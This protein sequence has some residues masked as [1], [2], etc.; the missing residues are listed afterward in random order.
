MI[1]VVAL[2]Q[3]PRPVLSPEVHA[4][5]KVTFRL[6]APGAGEVM[7]SR[8]GGPKDAMT[9]GDDGVWSVTIG[10]LA[11]D[12]YSYS[13]AVDGVNQLDPNNALMVPNLLNST[14]SM[15][16]VP[17]GM[18]WEVADVPHGTVHRHYYKSGV[19]GDQRDYYV[20]TPPGYD[21]RAK[22]QYPVL[23]LLHGFS[24]D[25]SGWTAVGRA[26]VI[27]D[28][29]IAQ[30]KAKPMIVVMTLGYGE[31]AY[32]AKPQP[33]VRDAGMRERNMTRFRDALLTEVIPAV[34]KEYRADRNR[35]Q[36]AIAGLSMGGG[37]SLFTGLNALETFAWVGAFSAGVGSDFSTNFPKLNAKS[38]SGLQLL[39][40]A[41]GKDDRLIEPNRKF[42][43]WL[44]AND[45]RHEW[46]ETE[47]AHTWLVWRRYLAELA[48]L[49]FR[50]RTT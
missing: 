16:L 26:N 49:L 24:D 29:L 5:R 39:W 30:G 10:P 41:C 2:A 42:V 45:I 36:R 34:E 20:Y 15:V 48:T 14:T 50:E 11:P 44:K 43:E 17:G 13:F 3:G 27:L 18:P 22:K 33:A 19:I 8:A 4:D 28:N 35:V 25:A 12:L 31:P 38:A 21:H 9:K 40:I 23:Y 46:K 37:E 1:S 7:V 6:K 47:G 32:V